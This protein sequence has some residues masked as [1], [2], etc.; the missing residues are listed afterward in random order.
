MRSYEFSLAALLAAGLLGCQQ[1]DVPGPA[2]PEGAS[3]AAPAKPAP[4]PMA[5]VPT[6]TIAPPA[7]AALPAA[8]IAP[9]AAVPAPLKPQVLAANPPARYAL[10]DQDVLWNVM[11]ALGAMPGT[12]SEAIAVTVS[13]GVVTV[14]GQVRDS[15]RRQQIVQIVSRVKGVQSVVDKLHV[16]ES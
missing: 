8:T 3:T 5:A 2:V 11:T 4:P 10:D 9:P 12:P 14:D 1:S 7:T 6:A 13:K 15:E 16:A